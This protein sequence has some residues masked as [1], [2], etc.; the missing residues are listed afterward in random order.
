MLVIYLPTELK[1]KASHKKRILKY[2][3]VFIFR[4]CFKKI[5]SWRDRRLAWL[6]EEFGGLEKLFVGLEIIWI[7]DNQLGGACVNVNVGFVNL[8]LSNKTSR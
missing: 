5:Q 6:S 2:I 7:P 8:L 1:V 3:Q 4:F